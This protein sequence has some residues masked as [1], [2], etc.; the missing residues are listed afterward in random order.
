MPVVRFVHITQERE[1]E[2]L[3]LLWR[4]HCC[5]LLQRSQ[6]CNTLSLNI[7]SQLC[8][9]R[10]FQISNKLACQ[11]FYESKE[12]STAVTVEKQEY[13][14]PLQHANASQI[15]GNLES[16]YCMIVCVNCHAEE[17]IQRVSLY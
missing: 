10:N 14:V 7:Y 15:L 6:A 12:P 1:E 17:V 2:F 13:G 9:P 5:L 11:P 4:T 3:H 16:K 8:K